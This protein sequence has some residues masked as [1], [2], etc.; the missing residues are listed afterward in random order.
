MC[1]TMQAHEEGSMMLA[2]QMGFAARNAVQAYDLAELGI[3]APVNILDGR[4][5]F[6]RNLPINGKAIL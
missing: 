5:G 2:M 4:F 3:T 1:G 6:F